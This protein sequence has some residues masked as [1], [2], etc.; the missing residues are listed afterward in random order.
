MHFNGKTIELIDTQNAGNR[1]PRKIVTFF[2]Q[3]IK[4]ILIKNKWEIWNI[5]EIQ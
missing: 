4:W 5:W 2:K 3:T 1:I